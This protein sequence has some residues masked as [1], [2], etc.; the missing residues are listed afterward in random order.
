MI[1]ILEEVLEGGT[2]GK[3]DSDLVG[4]SSVVYVEVGKVQYSALFFAEL[5]NRN[6]AGIVIIDCLF[7]KG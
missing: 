6:L 3:H 7:H 1:W 2:A 4:F 5:I